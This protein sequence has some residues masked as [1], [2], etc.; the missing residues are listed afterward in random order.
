MKT[1]GII[2]NITSAIVLIFCSSIHLYVD[3]SSR[4][5][6]KIPF[7]EKIFDMPYAIRRNTRILKKIKFK[8]LFKKR[9]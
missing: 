5:G 9:T 4:T 6:K 3:Y 7:F 8:N 1:I 2:I